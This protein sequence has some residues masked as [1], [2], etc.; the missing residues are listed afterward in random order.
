MIPEF[1]TLDGETEITGEFEE[2]T[3]W[4]NTVA[5]L[6]NFNKLGYKNVI[7]LDFDDL[8]TRDIPKVFK[9]YNY[10]TIKLISSSYEQ[11][12]NQMIN[13]GAGGLVDTSYLK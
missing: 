1:L 6:K 3:C 5:L 13:R 11:N 4:S 8:R 2:E 7:G 9:G 12:L 10:L